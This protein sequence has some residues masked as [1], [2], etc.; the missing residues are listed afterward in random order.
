MI[1]LNPNK[2]KDNIPG[3]AEKLSCVWGCITNKLFKILTYFKKDY[4][5]YFMAIFM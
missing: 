3:E 1:V 5:G 2:V 4:E